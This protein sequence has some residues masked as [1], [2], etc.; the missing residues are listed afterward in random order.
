M[1]VVLTT[2]QTKQKRNNTKNTVQV[3]QNTINTST[4]I[5]ITPAHTHIHTYTLAHISKQVTT[6]T[7]HVKTKTIQDIPK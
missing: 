6:K 4:H 5:T 3:T 2:V 7:D 1:A